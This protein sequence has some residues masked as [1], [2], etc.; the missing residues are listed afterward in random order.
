LKRLGK[1]GAA[2]IFEFLVQNPNKKFTRDQL[3]VKVGLI[4]RGGSFGNYLSSLKTK[5]L[6]VK[7]G[8]E[9]QLN[10]EL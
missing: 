6:I 8:Q 3:G 1:G 9:F 4:S 2:R 5:N 7:V 10:P